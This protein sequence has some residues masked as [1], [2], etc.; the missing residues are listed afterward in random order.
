MAKGKPDKVRLT[1]QS[2]SR[3][4]PDRVGVELGVKIL[5]QSS[6]PVSGQPFTVHV[7]GEILVQGITNEH[8]EFS[9]QRVLTVQE[10]TQRKV[11]L[12]LE[13]SAATDWKEVGVEKPKQPSTVRTGV[14]I[15]D[16][17]GRPISDLPFSIR[18]EGTEQVEATTDSRGEFRGETVLENTGGVQREVSLTLKVA[19]ILPEA[20]PNPD[21]LLQ[22]VLKGE[23]KIARG[24]EFHIN[25][26]RHRVGK[27]IVVE[28]SGALVL[29]PGTIL[30]FNPGSGILCQGVLIAVGTKEDPIVFKPSGDFW[31][32]I[33]LMGTGVQGSHLEYCVIEGGIGRNISLDKPVVRPLPYERSG[34]TGTQSAGGALLLLSTDPEFSQV[35]FGRVVKLKN[36][37]MRNCNAALPGTVFCHK[38]SLMVEDYL[39]STGKDHGEADGWGIHSTES[40]ILNVLQTAIAGRRAIR[41]D[42]IFFK[43]ASEMA[44]LIVKRLEV[45]VE[46]DVGAEKRAEKDAAVRK[47]KEWQKLERQE[48]SSRRADE[49]LEAT[50]EAIV[51]LFQWMA[52]WKW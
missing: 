52:S 21:E 29:A 2:E 38:A 26:G 35:D 5:D 11:F 13:G 24:E 9:G 32:N 40:F 10:G 50:G 16:P 34:Q 30:E 22:Q 27:D 6:L 46:Q 44:K 45:R 25:K 19:R 51:G 36:V 20:A 4:S 41:E 3:L 48:A 7:D 12:V 31:G 23:R 18:V 37:I 28:E 1:I 47:E 43:S 33:A 42:A 15:L 14:R 8:G 49:A 17:S 39:I